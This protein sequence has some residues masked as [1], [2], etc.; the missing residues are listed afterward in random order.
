MHVLEYNI[1]HMY[2]IYGTEPGRHEAWPDPSWKK[3]QGSHE[4][5]VVSHGTSP[6]HIF[7]E[8]IYT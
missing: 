1:L 3:K 4:Q 8:K 2:F 6:C 7:L 5:E